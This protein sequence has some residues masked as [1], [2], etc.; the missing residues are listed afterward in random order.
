MTVLPIIACLLGAAAAV[1]FFRFLLKREKYAALFVVPAAVLLLLWLTYI[2]AESIGDPVLPGGAVFF[3]LTF[4]GVWVLCGAATAFWRGFPDRRSKTAG[5]LIL[6]LSLFG[7]GVSSAALGVSAYLEKK[8]ELDN[9]FRM[10]KSNIELGLT[11]SGEAAL[12]SFRDRDRAITSAAVSYWVVSRYPD[13][14]AEKEPFLFLQTQAGETYTIPLSG[15][16]T[17]EHYKALK[18]LRRFSSGKTVNTVGAEIAFAN[19]RPTPVSVTLQNVPLVGKKKTLTLRFS[20]LPAEKSF[21]TGEPNFDSVTFEPLDGGGSK[22]AMT[23]FEHLRNKVLSERIKDLSKRP[24]PGPTTLRGRLSGISGNVTAADGTNY[25]VDYYWSVFP[26]KAALSNTNFRQGVFLLG[27]CFAVLCLLAEIAAAALFARARREEQTRRAFLSGAAHE[28]KTP[29][30]VIAN[31]AECIEA[32]V[33]PEKDAQYARI[34][35]EQ[36]SRMAS[37][38]QS[39]LTYRGLAGEAGLQKEEVDVVSLLKEEAENYRPAAEQKNVGFVFKG[40]GFLRTEADEKAARL[41]FDALLSNAVRYASP[42]TAVTVNAAK[43]ELTIEDEGERIKQEDLPHVFEPLYRGEASRA[44]DD[45]ATG[46]GLTLANEICRLH[47]WRLIIENTN[48]GVRVR[49]RV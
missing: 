2:I 35:L 36:T 18:A 8:T 45:G 1:F 30:A 5:A 46:M 15:L 21:S 10:Q 32:G 4:V 44:T 23:E 37:L 42:G 41:A 9:F 40:L 6:A 39:F 38:L 11:S 26:V 14:L 24:Q 49:V 47:G 13:V 22:K 16:L 12:E 34:V 31:A 17:E 29:V 43:R 25:R 19:G 28:L 7:W 33:A 20:D 27:V 48:A 3:V